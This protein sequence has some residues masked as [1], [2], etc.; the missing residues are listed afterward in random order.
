MDGFPGGIF[1]NGTV[2]VGKTTVAIC[3]GQAL[4]QLGIA[5]AVIDLDA[6]RRAWPAP[7][8]DRF[9]HELELVNLASLVENYTDAGIGTFVLA[10][11]IEDAGEIQRYRHA[12][13]GRPLGICRITA[14][15]SVLRARLTSR[16]RDDPDGLRWHL[17]R[18]VELDGILVKQS[19]DDFVVDSSVRSSES[20][21]REVLD[22]AG[23]MPSLG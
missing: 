14:D 6:I 10:G 5:H 12:L 16:H 22:L 23:Q 8:G 13:Q 2:G 11:V 18:A 19:L 1:L 20:V 17:N 15:A 4:Q 9:N 7:A 3:I 21:A